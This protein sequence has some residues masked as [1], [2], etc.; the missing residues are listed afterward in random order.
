MDK[1]GGSLPHR[2]HGGQRGSQVGAL[3]QINVHVSGPGQLPIEGADL[4]VSLDGIGIQSLYV[5]LS[6]QEVGGVPEGGARPVGLQGQVPGLIGL[7]SRHQEAVLLLLYLYIK[8]AEHIQ[9]HIHITPGFQGGSEDDS[10]V[11]RQ[12][13]QGIE[14][15]SDKLAGHVAGKGIDARLQLTCHGQAGPLLVP[16]NPLLLK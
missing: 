13:R 15:S 2:R 10:A 4:P 11:S 8:P 1:A 9:R 3:G 6:A 16:Q 14:Q 12:Q 5:H 7:V